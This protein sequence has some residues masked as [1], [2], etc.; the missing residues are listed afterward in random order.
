[1]VEKDGEIVTTEDEIR[2]FRIV[3]AIMADAVGVDRVTRRDVKTYFNVLLDDNN[4]QPICRLWL[5]QDPWY[6]ELIL[7]EEKN[8]EKVEIESLNEIYAYKDELQKTVQFYDD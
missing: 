4:R 3:R 1:V 5:N 2:G 7:D 6:L 8:T